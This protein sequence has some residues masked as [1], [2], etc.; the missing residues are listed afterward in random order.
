[1]LALDLDTGP[2]VLGCRPKDA[3]LGGSVEAQGCSLGHE[4]IA[5]GSCSKG[6]T[7]D[8]FPDSCVAC[9]DVPETGVV[10]F[11]LVLDF[12]LHAMFYEFL[13]VMAL[14]RA[15]KNVLPILVRTMQHWGSQI[16]PAQVFDLSSLLPFWSRDSVARDAQVANASVGESLYSPPVTL[17]SWYFDFMRHAAKM[18]DLIP[19]SIGSQQT[20]I[21][22]IV[23]RHWLASDRQQGWKKS[24][25][26][27]PAI[28]WALYPFTLAGFIIAHALLQS[29][30]IFPAYSWLTERRRSTRWRARHTR[31]NKTLTQEDECE[32]TLASSSLEQLNEAQDD[33]SHD[34]LHPV[35]TPEWV[36]IGDELQAEVAKPFRF[37]HG[38]KTDI[39]QQSVN[40]VGEHRGGQQP[41][42][43]HLF[44]PGASPSELLYDILPWLVIAMNGSWK[45][46]TERMT[47]LLYCE[48]F[49]LPKG[50]ERRLMMDTSIQCWTLRSTHGILILI[51]LGGILFE[52]VGIAFGFFW[53]ISRYDLQSM[54]VTRN[55]GY[56]ISGFEPKMW[57]WEIV[58]KKVDLLITVIITYTP[59][60]TDLTTK[61]LL[62]SVQSGWALT[63]QIH[64]A[65]FDNRKIKL[66]DRVETISLVVRYLLFNIL[67]IYLLVDLGITINAIMSALLI[68]AFIQFLLSVLVHSLDDWF[69]T[70][71]MSAC[72]AISRT[73]LRNAERLKL[74][75]KAC[76]D[77]PNQFVEQAGTT[78][79]QNK[80][81][82]ATMAMRI[83]LNMFTWLQ[84]TFLLADYRAC[85][86]IQLHWSGPGSDATLCE[87]DLY[88]GI[89]GHVPRTFL[90]TLQLMAVKSFFGLR[91]EKQKDAL[92]TALIGFMDL[93][94]SLSSFEHL[95]MRTI[96]MVFLLTQAAKKMKQQLTENPDVARQAP[97]GFSSEHQKPFTSLEMIKMAMLDVVLLNLRERMRERQLLLEGVRPQF[98][99]IL[100]QEGIPLLA[101]W[102]VLDRLSDDQL[103][104]A[105]RQPTQMFKRV[106]A[107]LALA[108]LRAEFHETSSITKS[109]QQLVQRMQRDRPLRQDSY[110]FLQLALRSRLEHDPHIEWEH[111][112]KCLDR[113]PIHEVSSLTREPQR[114]IEIVENAHADASGSEVYDSTNMQHVSVEDLNSTIMFLQQLQPKQFHELIEFAQLLLDFLNLPGGAKWREEVI[115][116]ARFEEELKRH[117]TTT[118]ASKRSGSGDSAGV[119]ED[120]PLFSQK[121][122]AIRKRMREAIAASEASG[123]TPGDASSESISKSSGK[124]EHAHTVDALSSFGQIPR[125]IVVAH[126]VASGTAGVLTRSQD[127]VP[128][129]TMQSSVDVRN[130]W[131][132]DAK[133]G[134]RKCEG[135]RE[136]C[137]S[138]I[139]DV[140]GD[141]LWLR[142]DS[143]RRRA[144]DLENMDDQDESASPSSLHS[145]SVCEM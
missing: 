80:P 120:V 49:Y 135:E 61:V 8:K 122:P 112:R 3:C 4:D 14:S 97:I 113:L 65:P 15:Q 100:L 62:Y 137:D 129:S 142:I 63:M 57:W 145:S 25:L 48:T 5:C 40:D 84:N 106:E 35:Y 27:V 41:L 136:P 103:G 78:E 117:A 28:W 108:K 99:E 54:F 134:N 77:E 23:D 59:L 1:M 75:S 71:R 116:K 18:Y 67:A 110:K 96:D 81:T 126:P 90:K 119:E 37:R 21:E 127:P 140:S 104:R 102:D 33:Q 128:C 76:E 94:L 114:C 144:R 88:E 42:L 44:R 79:V 73:L 39:I 86:L 11:L 121:M 141:P 17:P 133:D 125:N 68:A 130:A 64:L 115:R 139:A 7:R 118:A 46:I 22:C 58:F 124:C 74:R 36:S 89:P 123:T 85:Q 2:V 55:F 60:S 95:P 138:A 43:F 82:R 87:P 72:T 26:V 20:F 47:Q 10:L 109:A 24:K 34:R 38:C 143:L 19:G 32:E 91:L 45:V 83:R 111:V 6:F 9:E 92:L 31:R 69:T 131:E 66:L 51:G 53:I 29:K 30:I 105:S 70:Q 16:R 52:S 101:A 12:S 50:A 132:A 107:S 93:M 56:L 13:A 98:E